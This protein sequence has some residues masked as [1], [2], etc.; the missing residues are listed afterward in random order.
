MERISCEALPIVYALQIC[1]F[2]RKGS[3]FCSDKYVGAHCCI[4][5]ANATVFMQCARDYHH[6]SRKTGAH[7]GAPLHI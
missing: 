4:N 3:G 6:L 2:V 5:K 1:T 7:K